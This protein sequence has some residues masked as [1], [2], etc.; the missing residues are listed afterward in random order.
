MDSKNN[1]IP[2]YSRPINNICL[3]GIDNVCRLFPEMYK[4]YYNL[5]RNVNTT[6]ETIKKDLCSIGTQYNIN[7]C[8][9]DD[10]DTDWIIVNDNHE[11]K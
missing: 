8:I 3:S 5:N 2:V 7:D 1:I 9:I 6:N 4:H 10:C 11:N